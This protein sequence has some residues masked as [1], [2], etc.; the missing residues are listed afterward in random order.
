MK[1]HARFTPAALAL[2]V[3]TAVLAESIP[4]GIPVRRALWAGALGAAALCLLAALALAAWQT[5]RPLR[6]ARAALTT[7]LVWELV[8]CIGQAQQVCV[9]EFSSMALLGFLPLLLWAGWSIRPGGWNTPAR[10][11]WWLAA[12]G[13][14]V[15]LCGLGG[16][17]HWYRLLE[18]P[19]AA[20]APVW[21]VPV[22]AEYFAAPL[23]CRTQKPQRLL[24]LPGF[25]FLV[26]AAVVLGSAL[27][28]GGTAYPQREL[29]RAWSTGSF[30]RMDALLLL[31]W[32]CCAVYRI[33]V[34]CASIRLLWQPAA[35]TEVQ[36]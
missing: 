1:Q 6:G 15:C 16:Q 18:P 21:M 23:L 27:L 9:Q 14:L 5:E 29:L 34:L 7:G 4:Q 8:R 31:F 19:A 10:V 17:M 24:W 28:F 11:L 13:G 26:Q 30:S 3:E 12:A 2:S 20:A 25:S 32:L 33:A 35:E 22:Y 36:A